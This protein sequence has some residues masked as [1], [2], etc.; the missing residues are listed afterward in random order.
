MCIF[1]RGFY[2]YKRSL[3]GRKDKNTRIKFMYKD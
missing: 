2:F 3:V 1:L